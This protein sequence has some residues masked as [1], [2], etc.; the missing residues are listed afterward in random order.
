MRERLLHNMRVW[1]LIGDTTNIIPGY[2]NDRYVEYLQAHCNL[3]PRAGAVKIE[4]NDTMC[5]HISFD[6]VEGGLLV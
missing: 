5:R 3:E 2:N 4:I 6:H 1:H